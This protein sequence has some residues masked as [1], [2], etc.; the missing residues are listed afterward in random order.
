MYAWKNRIGRH[1]YVFNARGE[2]RHDDNRTTRWEASGFPVGTDGIPSFS[3]NFVENSSPFF[4]NPISRQA[5]FLFSGNYNYNNRYLFDAT[6]RYDGSTI[7]GSNK[8]FSPFWS[9]GVGWN[10][11][12]ENVIRRI[13]MISTLRFRATIGQLG[14]QNLS[15]ANSSSIYRY[16][17]GGNVHGPGV[18]VTAL[19]NP[20]IEWQKTLNSNLAM[21]LHLFDGR[22][23]SKFEV[24]KKHTNPLVVSIDQA[25]ST[26]AR[27]FPTSLGSLIYRG[28]EYDVSYVIIRTGSVNWRVKVMGSTVKG[29]F[30]GLGDKLGGID[31]AK[32]VEGSLMRYRDGYSRETMWA[33]RSLGIDAS[34]GRELF[35][36][37]D[38]ESSF[39]YDPRDIVA[40]GESR[41]KLM[42]NINSFLTLKQLTFTAV[43]RYAIKQ[44]R[45]NSALFSK[46][47][48]IS[49]NQVMFN[50][51]KRA[52]YDRWQTPGQFSQ[53]KGIYLNDVR[54]TPVMSDRFIQ[55]ESFLAAESIG[56]TW[57]CNRD[58][59]IK[60]FGM[61]R[62]DF[63]ATVTGTSGVFRLSNILQERG[64]SYPEATNISLSVSATF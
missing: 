50:Q 3:N 14:N 6:F 30:S 42:G 61:N 27:S 11:H 47:E 2:I 16:L 34:T 57:R 63:T 32:E 46:V 24:Y 31:V 53:F 20:N 48:N 15:N 64:T 52:L 10:L 25:P 39:V 55:N 51:D 38:G 1:D 41:P 7:F 35:L 62:L 4:S 9:T 12:E 26:G 13:R 60:N 23:T 18:T 59:W 8:K 40:V 36:T 44:S 49:M 33:V 28:F 29:E 17:L 37:R 56:V 22:F 43:F 5:N 21:D 54:Q 45:F 58:G 19:G